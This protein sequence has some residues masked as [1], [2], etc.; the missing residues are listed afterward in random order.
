MYY[1]CIIYIVIKVISN[2]IYISKPILQNNT[3]RC[4]VFISIARFKIIFVTYLYAEILFELVHSLHVEDR[5][6]PSAYFSCAIVRNLLQFNLYLIIVEY[7][8]TLKI[9]T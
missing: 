8:N 4:K 7:T 1:C 2:K 9:L 3:K 5:Y 6:A